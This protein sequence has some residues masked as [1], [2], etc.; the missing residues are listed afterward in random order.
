M[1]VPVQAYLEFFISSRKEIMAHRHSISLLEALPD[2]S[3]L[4]SQRTNDQMLDHA[5]NALP[6]GAFLFGSDRRLIKGRPGERPQSGSGSDAT[7][8]RPG[9]SLVR[10]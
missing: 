5:F 1:S 2:D 7:L 4:M 10:S 6:D 3:P 8:R 9:S